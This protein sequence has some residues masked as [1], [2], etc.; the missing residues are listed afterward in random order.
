MGRFRTHICV[1]PS[2]THQKA[3]STKCS[4]GGA[5]VVASA[6]RHGH[7]AGLAAEERLEVSLVERHPELA[8]AAVLKPALRA[9][10][11]RVGGAG[12]RRFLVAVM[13][14]LTE[15]EKAQQRSRT[16]AEELRSVQ[17]EIQLGEMRRPYTK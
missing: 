13:R 17:H 7:R 11:E 14:V 5:V 3:Q 6:A 1:M 12:Q 9:A 4:G 16:R 8:H 15:L 2:N 10:A